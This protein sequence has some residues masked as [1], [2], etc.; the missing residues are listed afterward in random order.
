MYKPSDKALVL[1][2]LGFERRKCRQL[3]IKSSS[4]SSLSGFQHLLANSFLWQV[5][6]GNLKLSLD[7]QSPRVLVLACCTISPACS[8]QQAPL[9]SFINPFQPCPVS[10]IGPYLLESWG[11]IVGKA[12]TSFRSLWSFQGHPW[13]ASEEMI[14]VLNKANPMG[15]GKRQNIAEL[16]LNI[17]C[18]EGYL[19]S[20]IS[21]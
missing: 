20:K 9:P 5:R 13:E 12:N 19:K 2:V 7:Q 18:K 3:Q 17:A 16:G 1:R 4:F 8:S 10:E 15:G 21:P 6:D 11:L 14:G